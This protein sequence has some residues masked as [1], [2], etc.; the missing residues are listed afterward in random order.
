MSGAGYAVPGVPSG[1]I[2]LYTGTIRP[3]TGTTW[4][5]ARC[6]TGSG[7]RNVPKSGN[8]TTFGSRNVPKSGNF[9]TF[10]CR[11][12]CHQATSG[13]RKG[14]HQATSGCPVLYMCRPVGA[15]CCT[16]AVPWVPGV[17]TVP[18][19]GCPGCTPCLPLGAGTRKPGFTSF[20]ARY[21]KTGFYVI[22][23]P[24]HP[25]GTTFGCPVH[26]FWDHLWDQNSQIYHFWDQN[27]PNLPLL[28]PK[29]H[30]LEPETTLLGA[31][32]HP[33]GSQKP[34]FWHHCTPHLV[35]LYTPFGT[36][37]HPIWTP[38]WDTTP[39]GHHPIGTP[40]PLDTH[41]DTTPLGHHPVFGPGPNNQ[42]KP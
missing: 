27:S 16:C 33:F 22:W 10:G 38:H 29:N 2:V 9:T 40:P 41:W 20:G 25:F 30:L 3:G 35:P 32:N 11:K 17:Y 42:T 8:F 4:A 26:P 36:T 6:F 28:G 14:C 21:Q 7:S 13:C 34:P 19:I 1:V 5:C 31:R 18:S 39:L 15:R 12:G 24:V 23:C 37:V